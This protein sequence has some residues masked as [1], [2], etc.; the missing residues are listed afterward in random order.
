[1]ADFLSRAAFPAVAPSV[2]SFTMPFP[3]LIPDHIHLF[4]YP[5][6]GVFETDAREL[7]RGVDYVWSSSG[8]ATL[9]APLASTPT[10]EARRITPRDGL[11]TRLTGGTVSAFILN[12]LST[13][14]LYLLQEESDAVLELTGRALQVPFPEAAFALPS[15][16]NRADSIFAFDPTGKGDFS[17]SASRLRQLIAAGFSP[18]VTQLAGNI[19]YLA[20]GDGMEGTTVLDKLQE[21]RSLLDAMPE[22]VR[23]A[24]IAGTNTADLSAYINKVLALGGTI[25]TLGYTYVIGSR[26]NPAPGTRLVGRGTF[27]ARYVSDTNKFSDASYGDG[28]QMLL[29]VVSGLTVEKGITFDGNYI[30]TANFW[31]YGARNT[32]PV[33]NVV[34][35]CTFANL[36]F[37][38][39]D[40]SRG[41]GPWTNNNIAV[42]GHIEN[43]GWTGANLEGCVNLNHDE[44]SVYRTGYHG[45]LVTHAFNVSGDNFSVNRGMP[46]YRIYNGPGGNGGIE[47]G[48]MLGHFAV[49][50]ARWSNFLLYDNR[51]A[52]EDGLGIGEDG[53]LSDPESAN[54]YVQGQIWYPGLFGLDVSSDMVADVQVWYPTRQGIQ[55]GLDLGGTIANVDV[56]AQVY[57]NQNDEAARFSATGPAP[58]TCS[59]VNGSATI[60][61]VSGSGFFLALGQRISGPGIPANAYVGSVSGST[62]T[63][64]TAPGGSTPALATATSAAAS[65]IF[66]GI[67]NFSNVRLDLRVA[68][69]I[70]GSA[71][72][73]G[74]TATPPIPIARSP[75]IFRTWP[76]AAW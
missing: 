68:A 75:G 72:R 6:G 37:V 20:N 42:R 17:I 74:Q 15:A 44:L 73:A 14:L 47:R 26:L 7:V 49:N 8:V 23:K 65:L 36:S 71:S 69:C 32:G 67:I 56:R 55:I 70:S 11:L 13:Q 30:P 54:I 58:R 1:M 4:V 12:T 25:D 19:S 22:A 40:I 41:G 50:I 33:N 64:V 76:S 66:R 48:F 31:V 52:N 35:D 62:V 53:V 10:L 63:M 16:G 28:L 60:T 57:N 61:I 21:R 39:V 43:C 34:L 45:I 27:V 18:A 38:G 59:T 3:A 29:R 2:T 9:L 46:P 5:V 24:V 51:N